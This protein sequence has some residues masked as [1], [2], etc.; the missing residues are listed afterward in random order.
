MGQHGFRSPR[1][2]R[3]RPRRPGLVAL[4]LERRPAASR[5]RGGRRVA[6]RV[7]GIV[8]RPRRAVHQRE[9]LQGTV[10]AA[11]HHR[12]RPVRRSA[13]AA[14]LRRQRRARPQRS[15]PRSGRQPGLDAWR[16]GRRA[17]PVRTI[18]DRTSPFRQARRGQRTREGHLVRFD[19]EGRQFELV[20][21]G[22]RNPFGVAYHR[23]GD[24]FTYDADAEFDMGSSWYRPTRVV[25]LVSGA[26][27]GWRGVTGSWPPYFPDHGGNSPP[28]CDIGKGRPRPWHSATAAS[29]R[30]R[31]ATRC[32]C[33]DWGVWTRDRRAP[34]A[35]RSGVPRPHRDVSARPAVECHRCGVW[36]RRRNVPGHWRTPNTFGAVSCGVDGRFRLDARRRQPATAAA[37]SARAP[38]PR[39]SQG[40]WPDCTVRRGAAAWTPAGLICQAPIRSFA[41]PRGSRWSTR[42][43][44][45]GAIGLFENEG[46][47]AALSALSALAASPEA[48][49]EQILQRL[50]SLPWRQLTA[51]QQL[52]LLHCDARCLSSADQLQLATRE[53][54]QQRL[55]EMLTAASGRVDV[56]PTG[57]GASVARVAARLLLQQQV[58]QAVPLTVALL[59]N[60][61]AQHDQFAYLFALRGARSGWQPGE[62]RSFFLALRETAAIRVATACPVFCSAC[63]RSRSMP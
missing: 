32:L 31:I 6:A 44:I 55:L 14:R 25:Q 23:D 56:L 16:R 37:D 62:R 3:H 5:I 15:G 36:S 10:S 33:L 41:T 2:D 26:D 19:P 8:V 18:T 29:S 53:A 9:Q 51:A 13:K 30:S 54:C 34:D 57:G 35:S 48:P 1:T 47:V 22:L 21:A 46:P 60:A 17:R 39:C 12:R 45:G 59:R 4:H 42:T 58:P 52:R 40:S 27:Y 20:C 63:A 7:P 28:L 50:N 11:G 43:S 24:A 61:T 38:V 49:Y